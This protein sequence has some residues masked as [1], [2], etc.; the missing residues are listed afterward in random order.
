MMWYTY[1]FLFICLFQFV[2]VTE[3]AAFDN[4]QFAE[5]MQEMLQDLPRVNFKFQSVN[6]TWDPTSVDYYEVK[7]TKQNK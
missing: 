4:E 1:L 7:K 5:N 2:H 3:A 6:S